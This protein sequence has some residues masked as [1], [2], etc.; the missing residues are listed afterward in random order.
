M[1]R[2]QILRSKCIDTTFTISQLYFTIFSNNFNLSFSLQNIDL[3]LVKQSSIYYLH[4]LNIHILTNAC[5][6]VSGFTN[7]K[8]WLLHTAQCCMAWDLAT[9]CAIESKFFVTAPIFYVNSG[10]RSTVSTVIT[11]LVAQD[12]LD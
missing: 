4:T 11:N 10:K 9:K 3:L 12:L 8:V 7:S 2:F 6:K 1:I 5:G